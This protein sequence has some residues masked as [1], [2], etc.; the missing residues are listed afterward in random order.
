MLYYY[1]CSKL[2]IGNKIGNLAI[3]LKNRLIHLIQVTK[4][5]KNLLTVFMILASMQNRMEKVFK[6][7]KED[8]LF[9]CC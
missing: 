4:V 9:A 3:F 8:I 2:I 1:A 7:K 5:K 6:R